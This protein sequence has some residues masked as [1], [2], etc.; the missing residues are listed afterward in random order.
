MTTL[1]KRLYKERGFKAFDDYCREHWSFTKTHANRMI[2]SAAVVEKVTPMG[3][4]PTSERQARELAQA[5]DP[6][7]V[8]AEVVE[9]HAPAEIT[10]AVI[11][12]SA[13]I[14]SPSSSTAIT[15]SPASEWIVR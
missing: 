13:S 15:A 14:I 4:T 9:Q 10:A 1:S 6:A 12:S 11:R 3:V 7:E 8:W 5:D 2:E